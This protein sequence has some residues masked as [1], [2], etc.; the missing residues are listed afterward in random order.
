MRG[1]GEV[2]VYKLSEV[3][4]DKSKLRMKK[5]SAVRF[6]IVSVLEITK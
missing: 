5:K 2:S 6:I 1:G 3:I 4:L